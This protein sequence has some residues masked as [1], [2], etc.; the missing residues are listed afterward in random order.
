MNQQLR[1]APYP[2]CPLG[3]WYVTEEGKLRRF[4]TIGHLVVQWIESHCIWT[5]GNW[6]GRPVKLLPWEHQLLLDMFE[7]NDD[8]SMRYRT[9]FIGVPKKNGKSEMAAFLAL[10]FF[11]EH[12][13]PSPN[14]AVSASSDYQA[15]IVF[16]SASNCVQLGPLA[17]EVDVFTKELQIPN[18]LTA[19]LQRV[20]AAGGQLDG[21][22]LEDV[23]ADELHE[24]LTPK[25]MKV[26]GMLRGA[27][28]LS[29][30]PMFL[31]ITTA[32]EDPGDDLDD[33]EVPPWLRLYRFGRAVEAGEVDDRTMFFRWWMAP[34]GADFRD[35]KV[36]EACNPSFGVTVQP[37]F[38]QDELNKRTESEFRRYYLN[39]PVE[40]INNWLEYGEWEACRV[41][42]YELIPGHETFMGW[43]ASTKR[44]STAVVLVQRWDDG[45]IYVRC[46]IWQRPLTVDGPER[47]WRVPRNDV[48]AYVRECYADF[49]IHGA[50]Y[51]PHQIAWVAEDLEDELGE[52]LHE[53]PQT[54]SRMTP[55][56]QTL[57]ESVIDTLLAHDGCPILT[58]HIKAAQ[59][60]NSPRGGQRIVKTGK[61]R[62]IDGAVALAMALYEM[63]LE[64]EIEE[65]SWGYVPPAD[66]EESNAGTTE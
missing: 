46:R 41:G 43:D 51:D 1:P 45:R 37:A 21:Q 40:A 53:F 18:H 12:G 20:A 23:I 28:A 11:L 3:P 27:L 15:D 33:E 61:G 19:K 35:M 29:A 39:Q 5:G 30:E 4:A 55:A 66:K 2:P 57:Y 54:D 9:A 49:D 62:M 59:V 6:V 44:D 48:L 14:V 16:G 50:G 24:W 17:D 31:A 52:T 60:K 22:R 26:Y 25:Q 38:Y 47:G 7:L 42:P 58:A 34:E 32:G 8:G 64:E 65:E 13:Y 10:Y 63:V 56:T 36:I